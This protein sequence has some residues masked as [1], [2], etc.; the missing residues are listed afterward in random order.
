MCVCHADE[1]N[2]S[3]VWTVVLQECHEC[4]SYMSLVWP[5]LSAYV[6]FRHRLVYVVAEFNYRDACVL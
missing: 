6:K 4:T 1:E 3:F 5:T 2:A